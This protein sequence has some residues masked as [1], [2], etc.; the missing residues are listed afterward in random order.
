M[1]EKSKYER[2]FYTDNGQ[3]FA[4]ALTLINV[5]KLS[6]GANMTLGRIYGKMTKR[7][8]LPSLKT[9]TFNNQHKIA[10]V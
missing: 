5:Q 9:G 7:Y 2:C 4:V 10:L 1:K 3:H 6:I 8:G